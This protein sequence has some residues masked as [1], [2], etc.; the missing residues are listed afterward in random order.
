MAKLF[1]EDVF[2]KLN[3][4]KVR[5]CVVGGVAAVLHGVMRMTID[6]D[7][8]V[9]M[10]PNNVDKFFQVLLELGYLP[11][12]PV[13]VEDFKDPEKRRTWVKEKNMKVFSFFHL[14]DHLKLIDVFIDEEVNYD[15]I[16]K[17]VIRAKR[18]NVPIVA[19]AD[20]KKL[21]LKAGRPMDFADINALEEIEEIRREKDEKP[22]LEK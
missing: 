15:K 19:I 9:D 12:V 14:K 17:E 22:K 13:A 2:R 20:L 6:L 11:K 1:Y 16:A 10:A 3:Q 18:V 8:I 21:K 5:Y 7:L 4:K